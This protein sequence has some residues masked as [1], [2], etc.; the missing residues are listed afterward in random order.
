MSHEEQ[1]PP[2]LAIHH[3]DPWVLL[4]EIAGNWLDRT[5]LPD[6]SATDK[7]MGKEPTQATD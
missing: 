3:K 6:V 5:G 4:V 2:R 7:D 1:N